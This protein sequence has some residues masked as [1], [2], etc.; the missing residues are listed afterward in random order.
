[1][2]CYVVYG[3]CGDCCIIMDF[4]FLPGFLFTALGKLGCLRDKS[5]FPMEDD[6]LV[7]TM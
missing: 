5:S 3:L 1:M 2:I 6:M 7:Y 4:F